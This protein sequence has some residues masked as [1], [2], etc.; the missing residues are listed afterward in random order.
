MSAWVAR[1]RSLSRSCN[2]A[3]NRAAVVNCAMALLAA[4][5]GTGPAWAW[6]RIRAS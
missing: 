1:A 3:Q 6:R 2:Q 5:T 4:F